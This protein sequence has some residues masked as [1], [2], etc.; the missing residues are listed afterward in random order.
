MKA[1]IK[2][3]RK[4]NYKTRKM[5]CDRVRRLQ[6]RWQGKEGDQGKCAREF[7]VMMVA[8]VTLLRESGTYS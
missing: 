8:I 4:E 3:E 1:R 2:C 7:S 5:M 6:K